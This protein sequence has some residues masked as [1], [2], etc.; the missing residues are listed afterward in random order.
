L[1]GQPPQPQPAH[2]DDVESSLR[3]AGHISG[4]WQALGDAAGSVGVGLNRIRVEPGRWSTPAHAHGRSEEIF[5]VLGGRGL[6]WQAGR[7]YE[8]ELGDVLVHPPHGDAH[9]LCAGDEGLEVL[10]LGQRVGDDACHL[11]RAS[12][13]WLGVSW[14]A[15]GGDHPWQREA[16]AGPP[17]LP[18]ASE[19]P[20]RIVRT[21][22]VEPVSRSGATVSRRRRDLGRAAGSR[23][24]GIALYEVEAGKLAVPPHCHSAEE[25]LFVLL[26][27]EGELLLGDEVHAVRRGHVV[28]RPPGTGVAH[29]FRAGPCGLALLAYGTREPN[30]IC[31]YPRSGK[32]S[33]RG[34]G[35]VGRIEPLDY[36]QGED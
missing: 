35:V 13:S 11:P 32:I 2:W 28:A 31:F 17:E 25:E 23:T 15:A 3:S 14:V 26:E 19:R 7:T 22:E 24:T 5:V 10:A 12:V 1:S 18:P 33:F 29:A 34:V 30:D 27:G 36:W 21:A 16:A 8:L 6:S 20:P 9:T 4:H